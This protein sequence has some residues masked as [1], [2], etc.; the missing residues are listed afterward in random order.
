MKTS[1]AAA[2]R[3]SI[4]CAKLELVDCGSGA[5][6]SSYESPWKPCATGSSYEKRTTPGTCSTTAS[7][8][9]LRGSAASR[10]APKAF[11]ETGV[12]RTPVALAAVRP[13][14]G[15]TRSAT[16][17]TASEATSMVASA[18]PSGVAA[19]TV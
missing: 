17:T 12:P 1:T 13:M 10:R 3:G 18:K 19:R 6:S 16:S 4:S 2:L 11:S 9:S 14:V 8:R 5:P 15:V 7:S